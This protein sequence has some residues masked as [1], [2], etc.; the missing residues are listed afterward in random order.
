V[1]DNNSND[2]SGARKSPPSEPLSPNRTGMKDKF[3]NVV[4]VAIAV[5][6]IAILLLCS[7]VFRI[8]CMV[9]GS[10]PD[11]CEEIF[12]DDREQEGKGK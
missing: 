10:T 12:S 4:S 2:Y 7:A 5:C 6:V 3:L 11:I 8:W 9:F 1:A